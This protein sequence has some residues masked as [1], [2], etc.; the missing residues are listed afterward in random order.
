MAYQYA[1]RLLAGDNVYI[2]VADRYP[3]L[4]DRLFARPVEFDPEDSEL[5]GAFSLDPNRSAAEIEAAYAPGLSDEEKK[6]TVAEL[7]RERLAGRPEYGDRAAIGPI[8]LIVRDVDEEGD[9]TAI[10]LSLEPPTV[11]VSVPVFLSPP[12]IVMSLWR[13]FRAGRR[14]PEDAEAEAGA[15][16]ELATDLPPLNATEGQPPADET[17]P[18]A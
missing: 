4:L 3:P 18:R 12:D 11:N 14:K 6:M 10:G 5:F 1:G 2:F 13:K 15:A 7:V 8:E 17:P 9:I 16:E